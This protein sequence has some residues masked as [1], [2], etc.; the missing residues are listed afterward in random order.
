MITLSE[1]FKDLTL[2]SDLNWD[3]VTSEYNSE[4]SDLSFPE[5]LQQKSIDG[6]CPS[7]LFELA[8]YEQAIFELK[9]MKPQI[10]SQKGIYLNPRSLFLSLDFDVQK[11][12]EDA[13]K[14]QI[15]VHEKQHVLCL[16]K[17]NDEA[18]IALNV[19]E[20]DLLLL[21]TLEEQPQEDTSFIK[22]EQKNS[23]EKFLKN[24]LIWNIGS[25]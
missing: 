6:D 19:S 9:N 21:Q 11:M 14:G 15:E 25:A 17:N 22:N 10:P 12:L 3:A 24:G 20:G 18:I 1:M 13:R 4:Y 16:F 2:F 8:F 23:F 7:Y 5:Y